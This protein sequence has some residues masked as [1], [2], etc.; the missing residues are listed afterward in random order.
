M[1]T[2]A[3]PPPRSRGPIGPNGNRYIAISLQHGPHSR[4]AHCPLKICKDP[5]ENQKQQKPPYR[6]R[7]G[8]HSSTKRPE[9]KSTT[10]KIEHLSAARQEHHNQHHEIFITQAR[11]QTLLFKSKSAAESDFDDG[12]EVLPSKFSFES[13]TLF[14][15]KPKTGISF[16]FRLVWHASHFTC[17]YLF[18]FLR[19]VRE[20]IIGPWSQWY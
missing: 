9:K 1:L 2:V 3:S 4:G 19:V 7:T 16:I 14:S 8:R 18:Y 10:S 20:S 6:T 15:S 12:Q 11:F 5:K 13:M 17:N